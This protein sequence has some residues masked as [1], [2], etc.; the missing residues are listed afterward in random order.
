MDLGAL[1]LSETQISHLV[2]ATGPHDGM[3]TWTYSDIRLRL[4]PAALAIAF[5]D[6]PLTLD[7]LQTALGS[8][9]PS[10]VVEDR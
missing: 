10:P 8:L 4:Y 3:P 1:S 7:H 6:C 2:D 5:P 9:R